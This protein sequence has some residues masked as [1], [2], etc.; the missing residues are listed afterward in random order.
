MSSSEERGRIA[1]DVTLTHEAQINLAKI[2]HEKGYSN[3]AI[4][5]IMRVNENSVR[6]LLAIPETE[7]TEINWG[8]NCLTVGIHHGRPEA[9]WNLPLFQAAYMFRKE[10]LQELV[11]ARIYND[12]MQF[13]E[14]GNHEV[15]DP[16]VTP[17]W[18]EQ[19]KSH[20]KESYMRTLQHKVGEISKYY[21]SLEWLRD[22]QMV[23]ER[24]KANKLGRG[25]DPRHSHDSLN[26]LCRILGTSASRKATR[27]T[28][29]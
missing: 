10:E 25:Y 21:Q 24:V 8:F 6:I 9:L 18:A 15:V 4:A 14:H 1:K 19:V 2:L 12:A 16:V 23:V 28:E 11:I 20:A 17:E 26:L 3:S 22:Q 7:T 29:I 5:N 13:V 27:E